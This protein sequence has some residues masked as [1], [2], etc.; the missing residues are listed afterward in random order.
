[1][2]AILDTSFLI[3]TFNHKDKNHASVIKVAR[4][5]NE[6]LVLPISVLPEVCYLIAS[7]MGH[8]YMRH[9]LTQLAASNTILEPIT[10]T[11][12]QRIVEILE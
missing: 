8:F 12:L 6:S 10:I 2:A 9:F 1:M 11:D 3:A 4:E 5:L 7:R